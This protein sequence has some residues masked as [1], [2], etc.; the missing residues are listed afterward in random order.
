MSRR[1]AKFDLRHYLDQKL[2][3][4]QLHFAELCPTSLSA[5]GMGAIGEEPYTGLANK[6]AMEA[7]VQGRIA[8]L[9]VPPADLS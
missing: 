7:S 3:E 1:S 5:L 2:Y 4:K 9:A 6:S 8:L